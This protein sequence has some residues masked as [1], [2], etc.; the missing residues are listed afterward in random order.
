[1]MLIGVLAIVGCASM[2][3][4]TKGVSNYLQTGTVSANL[5]GNDFY[6]AIGDVDLYHYGLFG[7]LKPSGKTVEIAVVIQADK[8]TGEVLK[9][10]TLQSNNEGTVGSSSNLLNGVTVTNGSNY[11]LSD[12]R[13]GISVID[14]QPYPRWLDAIQAMRD[15]I[16]KLSTYTTFAGSTQGSLAVVA[17][18]PVYPVWFWAGP[19]H[20]PWH[21]RR[22][23][24]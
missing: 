9:I 1:M 3:Q 14:I 22:H 11:V 2:P 16:T 19:L 5:K 18:T 10:A 7:A 6:M 8:D 13:G 15:A 24:R 21:N 20:G 12:L 4:V 17:V 23:W